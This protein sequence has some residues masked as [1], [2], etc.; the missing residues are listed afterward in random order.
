MRIICFI[1][2]LFHPGSSFFV[3]SICLKLRVFTVFFYAPFHRHVNPNRFA[4]EDKRNRRELSGGFDKNTKEKEE[5]IKK[6]E[7][8][9]GERDSQDRRAIISYC[10]ST[11]VKKQILAP[12]LTRRGARENIPSAHSNGFQLII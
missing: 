8:R 1:S 11:Q 4:E 6:R 12:A 7:K 10:G 9:R 2:S 5:E 3:A